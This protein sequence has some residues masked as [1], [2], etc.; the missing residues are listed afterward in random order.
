M[1]LVWMLIV[2]LRTF[3]VMNIPYVFFYKF[4]LWG[5]NVT[6]SLIYRMVSPIKHTS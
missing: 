1:N 3:L 2:Q 4:G 6:I 5:I